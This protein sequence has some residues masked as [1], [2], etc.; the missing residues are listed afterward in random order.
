MNIK[1]QYDIKNI[2]E[3]AG[4]TQAPTDLRVN[5]E[6]LL[7]MSLCWWGLPVDPLL[8]MSWLNAEGS[9]SRSATCWERQ[10]F[11]PTHQWSMVTNHIISCLSIRS[12]PLLHQID[13]EMGGKING[14]LS[15]STERATSV[16][17]SSLM[18]SCSAVGNW[19]LSLNKLT[20]ANGKKF[21]VSIQ[22]LVSICHLSL[23]RWWVLP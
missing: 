11:S 22:Q 1:T 16:L 12:R 2:Q 20:D 18:S 14:F 5:T 9:G 17:F 6:L 15:F 7:E 3:V 19:K 10:Q 21:V 13:G 8:L 4:V 23:S